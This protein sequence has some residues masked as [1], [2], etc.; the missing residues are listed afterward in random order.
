MIGFRKA[1]HSGAIS[2]GGSSVPSKTSFELARFWVDP[3]EGR[4]HVFIG[5]QDRW[6]PDLLG[7]LLIESIYTAAAAYAAVSD[8][9]ESEALSLI[10]RGLDDERARLSAEPTKEDE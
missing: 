8:M 5:F 6:S 4:A 3:E 2:I 10:W 9:S 1:E 7:S